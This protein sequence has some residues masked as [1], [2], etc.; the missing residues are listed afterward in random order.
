MCTVTYIPVDGNGYILTSSRDEKIA[1]PLATQPK[2]EEYPD[3]MLL[4]PK[5]PEGGGTWIACN[6]YGRTVCLF[7]GA[8]KAHTPK[9]PY[10]HSRGLIVLDFFNYDDSEI[11]KETYDFTNIEPFTLIILNRKTLEEFKWDGE[12]TY[13]I[14]RKY[15][16]PYIWSSVTLYSSDVIKLR[17][18]WFEEWKTKFSTPD[19]KN[20]IDFHL[21]AGNGNKEI[22]VLM[23]RDRLSLKTV[24]ITSIQ[25]S[26]EKINM[27]YLDLLKKNTYNRELIF[28]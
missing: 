5:D 1:R 11:F 27:K 16:E 23:E 26:D 4:F 18:S 28:K 12:D 19:Q 2:I 7:N 21:S 3:Y 15:N 10:R 25:L 13:L 8:F 14:K 6:N 17:E 22:D 20:I 9:Y 24:S